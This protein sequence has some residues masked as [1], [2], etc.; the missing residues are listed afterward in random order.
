MLADGNRTAS[1]ASAFLRLA[2][3]L[4]VKQSADAIVGQAVRLVTIAERIRSGHPADGVQARSSRSRRDVLP[5][6]PQH[7]GTGGNIT[8]VRP[9]QR[10]ANLDHTAQ[11]SS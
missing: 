1:R 7:F 4:F 9:G 5:A 10:Y 3:F 6:D 2:E 8:A 11:R